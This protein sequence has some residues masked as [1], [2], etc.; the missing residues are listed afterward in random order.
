MQQV[1]RSELES[2]LI[3]PDAKEV[4][5][6]FLEDTEAYPTEAFRKRSG[7]C[8]VLAEE[9]LPLLR[10][11]RFL[12]CVRSI[13]LSPDSHAGPDGEIRLWMRPAWHV[14][15]TC[16]S[17]GYDRALMREQ[18]NQGDIVSSGDRWRDPD[19]GRV[20]QRPEAYDTAEDVRARIDRIL[21]AIEAKE[22]NYHPGTDTLIVQDDPDHS[23]YLRRA[24]LRK[25][26]LAYVADMRE[27]QYCRTFI[28][29]GDDVVRAR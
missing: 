23:G 28:L 29:F 1:E 21:G 15:I 16:S 26:V 12:R 11:A 17:E 14:Q 6:R 9:Y 4:V 10:L 22:S 5:R 24:N 3:L 20:V 18:M 13:C 25:Q 2:H 27:T 19:T 7:I 8:K